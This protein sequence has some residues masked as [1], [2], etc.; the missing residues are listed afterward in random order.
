MQRGVADNRPHQRALAH[1]VAAK[2][3]ERRALLQREADVLED[4]GRAVAGG[5]AGELEEVRHGRI[6]PGT[7]RVPRACSADLAGVPS[8]RIAPATSTAIRDAK[9]KTTSMSCSMSST[10]IDAGSLLD[11]VEDDAD[12]GAR[13]TGGGLVEQQQRRLERQRD[14][15][16]HHALDAVRQ[17]LDRASARRPRGGA[18]PESRP[19]ARQPSRAPPVRP[20]TARRRRRCSATA[21]AR[22]SS[23]VS[24]RNRLVIWN[25]RPMPA[26]TR[27]ASGIAVTSRPPIRMVPRVRRQPSADQVDERRLA[28]AVGP[29]ERAAR[30]LLQRESSRRA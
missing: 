30:A 3:R 22:F 25:V 18:S 16:L 13:H 12:V 20:Q 17:H 11:G 19:R 15:E 10:A 14:P 26:L 28:G 4:D 9:R 27:A 21:S 7:G 24:R 1:A 2:H 6:R 29:D 5:D 23:T 8:T